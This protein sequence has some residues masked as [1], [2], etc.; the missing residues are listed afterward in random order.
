MGRWGTSEPTLGIPVTW[1]Q[2]CGAK[3]LV[4]AALANYVV[5]PS[6][7]THFMH[8]ITSL[9]VGYFSVGARDDL[10]DWS[11]LANSRRLRRLSLSGTSAQPSRC[12]SR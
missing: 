4:E 6:Y 2:I 9:N 5:E 7:G 12:P 11:W 3:L 8:N 1:S 10:V